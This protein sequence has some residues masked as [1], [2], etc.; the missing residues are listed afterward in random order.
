MTV[1]I[2][3]LKPL[4]SVSAGPPTAAPSSALPAPSAEEAPRE[5][6]SSGGGAACSR[7]APSDQTSVGASRS[8]EA[9]DTGMHIR[10]AG[11]AASPLLVPEAATHSASAFSCF[12]AVASVAF[13]YS[14]PIIVGG[15]SRETT[16]DEAAENASRGLFHKQQAGS[17]ACVGETTRALGAAVALSETLEAKLNFQG[18]S[19]AM[20]ANLPLPADED[21]TV[22][23]N[24]T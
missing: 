12:S 1:V 19:F 4:D 3:D 16:S 24:Q 5:H 18:S 7:S 21:L 8:P 10:E 17:A 23:H 6:R 22:V 15:A 11:E 20:T 9:D 13:E 2:V 14:D